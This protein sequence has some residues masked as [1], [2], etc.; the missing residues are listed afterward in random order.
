MINLTPPEDNLGTNEDREIIVS[1]E[2]APSHREAISMRTAVLD[3]VKVDV[4][5]FV[6]T[7]L[8]TLGE[9]SNCQPGTVVT[10]D[11]TIADLVE[12]RVNGLCVAV[13]E[14]VSVGDQFGV[15]ISKI[16]A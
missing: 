13:G 5:A 6:G 3:T 15:R 12:L 7:A 9:I 4:E 2:A 16:C 11:R 8:L 10:L 14:L 1:A